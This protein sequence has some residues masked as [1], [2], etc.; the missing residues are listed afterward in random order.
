MLYTKTIFDRHVVPHMDFDTYFKRNYNSLPSFH[1]L[2]ATGGFKNCCGGDFVQR[3]SGI[4]EA[5]FFGQVRNVNIVEWTSKNFKGEDR[6]CAA[7]V[8]EILPGGLYYLWNIA[9][10]TC[11]PFFFDN[12]TQPLG[13]DMEATRATFA[14]ETGAIV[15]YNE[16]PPVEYN[17]FFADKIKFSKRR[18]MDRVLESQSY[19][20]DLRALAMTSKNMD[21]VFLRLILD[22]YAKHVPTAE[23]CR[24]KRSAQ[25][26]VCT[27]EEFDELKLDELA[28]LRGVVKT[29]A[30]TQFY[31]MYMSCLD[32][33]LE[34]PINLLPE[35]YKKFGRRLLMTKEDCDEWDRLVF[36]LMLSERA[37]LII[38]SPFDASLGLGSGSRAFCEVSHDD[39]RFAEKTPKDPTDKD[40]KIKLGDVGP[41]WLLRT[42]ERVV[43]QQE[44]FIETLKDLLVAQDYEGAL[45]KLTNGTAT[46]RNGQGLLGL[47]ISLLRAMTVGIITFTTPMDQSI[48]D[49]FAKYNIVWTLPLLSV[50]IDAG[51]DACFDGVNM[52]LKLGAPARDLGS[53]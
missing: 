3:E 39:E 21:R 52:L 11:D 7:A 49:M 20:A 15:I 17:V 43:V 26:S 6:I 40:R 38:D 10:T 42:T 1:E 32:G 29:L 16:L 41:N 33:L 8:F 46:P 14:S 5:T 18:I 37:R 24:D 22:Q 34:Y 48:R 23:S 2:V 30:P 36:L 19:L 50:P 9:F 28:V 47:S 4:F 25:G 53:A 12:F 45:D 44:A 35:E 13:L 27:P 51:D 31:N